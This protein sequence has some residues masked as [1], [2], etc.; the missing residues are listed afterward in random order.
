MAVVERSED[1]PL[2]GIVKGIRAGN[3]KITFTYLSS[4]VTA[5]VYVY[6]KEADIS[7]FSD[8]VEDKKDDEIQETVFDGNG[9][10]N[11]KLSSTDVVVTAV[12]TDDAITFTAEEG[13]DSYSWIVDGM[14]DNN[15][16]NIYRFET[17]RYMP[18]EYEISLLCLRNGTLYSILIQFTI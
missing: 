7:S 5:S 2:A 1:N 15:H 8:A 12:H 14:T 17:A 16:S 6:P 9:I 10:N 4:T 18:G 11:I 3:A 13:C